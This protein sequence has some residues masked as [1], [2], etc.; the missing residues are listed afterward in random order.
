MKRTI[1]LAAAVLIL[2][3]CGGTQATKGTAGPATTAPASST[4]ASTD[5]TAPAAEETTTPPAA[6]PTIAKVGATQWFTYEDNLQVQVTRMTR[7][8]ISDS[9]AGG[10]PGDVGVMVTVTIKNGTGQTF[11]AAGASLSLSAGPNGD[12]AE[13]VFDSAN[14][15]NGFEGSIPASRSKTAKYG[16]AVPKAKLSKLVVEVAPA[17]EYDGTFFEGSVK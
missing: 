13:D 15:I 8:R 4:P 5:S 12:Q 3:G 6:D 2:G 9:A 17:Y 14:G 10:K 16:F 7:F 11:D 1:A